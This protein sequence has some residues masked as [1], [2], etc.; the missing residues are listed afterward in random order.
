MAFFFFSFF[1]VVHLLELMVEEEG[2]EETCT[3]TCVPVME[4]C[5]EHTAIHWKFSSLTGS[6]YFWYIK[7]YTG[8]EHVL[9]NRFLWD[10]FYINSRPSLLC[11]LSYSDCFTNWE[12]NYPPLETILDYIMGTVIFPC[13]LERICNSF[14]HKFNL[15]YV[16]QSV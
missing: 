9:H 2:E 8:S 15:F 14:V 13:D 10:F 3:C 7:E 5:H 1:F 11:N 6:S 16:I 12:E 4:T